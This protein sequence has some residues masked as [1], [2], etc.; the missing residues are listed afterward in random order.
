MSRVSGDFPVQRASLIGRSAACCRVVLPVCL[1]VVSSS[2]FHD[3]DT[4]GGQVAIAI[5]V[6]SSPDTSDFLVTR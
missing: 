3:H 2:K 5:P 1:S 6:A 4:H